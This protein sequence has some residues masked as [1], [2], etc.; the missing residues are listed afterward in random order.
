MVILG[1]MGN[2]YGPIGGALFITWL[3]DV[4]GSYMEYSLPLFGVIL[5]LLL[6]FFPEGFGTGLGMRFVY[7]ISYFPRKRRRDEGKIR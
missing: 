5:I 7:L 6:I 3:M 2:L 4:L 1:G